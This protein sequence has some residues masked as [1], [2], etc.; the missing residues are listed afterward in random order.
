[1]DSLK[2]RDLEP[3]KDIKVLAQLLSI[4]RR[5]NTTEA[6]TLASIKNW[7]DH[8]FV[9]RLVGEVDG[10]VVAYGRCAQIS[11]IQ[12][13]GVDVIVLP[14]MRRKGIGTKM[15]EAVWEIAKQKPGILPITFIQDNDEGSLTFAGQLGFKPFAEHFE[16]VLDLETFDESEYF[17]L[18]KQLEDEGIVLKCMEPNGPDE[19]KRRYGDCYIECDGNTP[20]IAELGQTDWESLEGFVFGAAWFR[21][22]GAWYAIQGDEVVGVSLAGPESDPFD[23]RMITDFTGVRPP[24]QKKGIATAL[25]AKVAAFAK[26]YGATSVE[27]FNSS[28]NREMLAVNQRIG[29]KRTKGR[30]MLRKDTTT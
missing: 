9:R 4:W 16:S 11:N 12:S 26:D 20:D 10:Q 28:V 18:Y 30:I 6:D 24:W 3:E 13:Y 22:E 7:P 25:K 8:L 21:P 17:P 19:I 5:N 23:G 29:F 27:T 2:I 1:M 14:E 15:Y